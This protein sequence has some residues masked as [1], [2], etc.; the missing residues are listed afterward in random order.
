MICRGIPL[1]CVFWWILNYGIKN[2]LNQLIFF[3][4]ECHK[5][6][7]RI[8]WDFCCLIRCGTEARELWQGKF[9]VIFSQLFNLFI[10]HLLCKCTFQSLWIIVNAKKEILKSHIDVVVGLPRVLNRMI[11]DRMPGIQ[12]F[13]MLNQAEK[14]K[15]TKRIDELLFVFKLLNLKQQRYRDR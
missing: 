15:R 4:F 1:I 13:Q 10:R 7:C 14:E 11:L 2:R 6:R 9:C 8:F 12:S 5:N 3:H